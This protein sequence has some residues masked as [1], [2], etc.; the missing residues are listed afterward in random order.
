MSRRISI[1][2]VLIKKT[3][4]PM[5]NAKGTN[6]FSEVGKFFKENDATS[7][8]N[9]IMDM[10]SVLK[11]S[12]KRLF[13]SESKCNCKLTQLQLLGLLLLFPCFMIR[14]AY[15]Y[16]SSSLCGLFRCKSDT[17]YRFLSRDTYDWRKIL[18]TVSWQLWR[19][20]QQK[21][22]TEAA[23]PVCLMVDDTDYPKRG[24]QAEL[25][26]KVFSHVTHSMML[27]FKALFLGITDG[28]SQMLIDFAL[29]GE[30]GKNRNYGLKQKQLDARFSK[31]HAEDSHTAK[32]IKEYD[33]SKIVLMID[34]I[35]R[36]IKQ[37][38]HFDYILA[39][40]WFAC[41]EIIKFVTSRH[42][43][44]HYLGMIK[45]S[46]TKYTYNGKELTANQIVAIHDH[47]KKGRKYSRALGCYYITADVI[48]AGRNVR[49]FF[50][51]RGKWAKWNGLITTS[52]QL[53][54]I[55]AYRI[56]SMR[57]SLEVVFKES[58]QNL[59]LGKYQMRFFSSQIAMTAITAMQYNLLSTAKRFSDYETIGGL[60]KDAAMSSVELTLTERIW[61]MILEIV[62]EIAEC[63]NIED[64]QILDMLVNRSDKLC[65]FVE[66]YQLKQAS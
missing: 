64:E 63:F 2:M 5:P 10:T 11:L 45:M 65:H 51:K 43:G 24:V 62:R 12:E 28:R 7:A 22:T 40:S 57:W 21:R 56:Y 17:F 4:S 44:C 8:M 47:P 31:G 1:F 36:V 50:C 20:I 30:K 25:I 35:K 33:Q 66:I 18:A 15:N 16:G 42:V 27:G 29:V 3:Q 55:D 41:A 23:G 19:K 34:M 59:G 26:G 6:I 38:I 46:R 9:A 37:K 54:F 58:K 14:N 13:G 60:F 48:F 49:L 53:G 39:D 32:R 61:N 52:R